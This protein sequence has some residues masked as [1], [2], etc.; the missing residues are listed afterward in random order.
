VGAA[1]WRIDQGG[2]FRLDDRRQ[3]AAL[4]A[5]VRLDGGNVLFHG[6]LGTRRIPNWTVAFRDL[7]HSATGLDAGGIFDRGVAV[8]GLGPPVVLLDQQP[9]VPA[10]PALLAVLHAD[11]AESALQA[12]AAALEGDVAPLVRLGSIAFRL[13][14]AAVPQHHGT[15]A[16][17]ALWNSAFEGAVF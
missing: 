8:S 10:L 17:F 12:L 3:L 2:E 15:A 9:V 6:G 4:A 5:F 16:V 1:G 13:P 14:G 7:A 11:Q